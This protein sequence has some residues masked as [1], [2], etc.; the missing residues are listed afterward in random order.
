LLGSDEELQARLQNFDEN[1][2]QQKKNRRRQESERQD[3]EDELAKAR[4]THVELVNEQGELAAEA[5]AFTPLLLVHAIN[6]IYAQSRLMNAA[7][8]NAKNLFEKSATSITS[9]ATAIALSSVKRSTSSSL[10]SGTSNVG[11]VPSSRSFGKRAKLRTT[12]LI[13]SQGNW[14]RSYRALR[15]N[16]VTPGS[17]LYVLLRLQFLIH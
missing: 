16:G 17:R 5:K 1:I 12:S 13:A 4:R 8:P 14:I 7:Y 3:L 15:C 9:R 2:S 6:L 10:D 11:N